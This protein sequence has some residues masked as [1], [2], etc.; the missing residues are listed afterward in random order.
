MNDFW[1]I[2]EDWSKDAENSVL[3]YTHKKSYIWKYIKIEN[4]QIAKLFHNITF[5]LY[6]CTKKKRKAA[7]VSKSKLFHI[8]SYYIYKYIINSFIFQNVPTPNICMVE[9]NAF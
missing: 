9:Y 1:R 6:F 8:A 3:L 7:L 4:D 5:L 2:T